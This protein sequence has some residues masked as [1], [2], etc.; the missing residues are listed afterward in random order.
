[1]NVWRVSF[2]PTALV[3]LVSVSTALTGCKSCGALNTNRESGTSADSSTPDAGQDAAMGTDAF[4]PLDA[5]PPDPT[6]PNNSMRDDD[7]DGLSDQ[8][9]FATTWGPTAAQTDP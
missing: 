3:V 8:Y 9:E 4:V 5:G 6:D 1:M 7:C 2:G